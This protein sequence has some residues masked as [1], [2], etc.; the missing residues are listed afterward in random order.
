VTICR[1]IAEIWRYWIFQNGGCL[2]LGFLKFEGFNGWTGQCSNCVTVPNLV[3][4]GQSVGDVRYSDF[5]FFTMAAAAILDFQNLD[6][7]K[8]RRSRGSTCITMPN[9][10]MIGQTV[11]E[12]SL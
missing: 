8:V 5:L 3:A 10:V 4:I 2:H 7:L 12:I 6:Y 9:S 11:A 1:I